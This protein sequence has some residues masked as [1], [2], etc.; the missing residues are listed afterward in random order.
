[1]NLCGLRNSASAILF[2][3]LVFSAPTS[4][5]AADA[6]LLDILLE[7]EQILL[8]RAAVSGE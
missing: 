1:M 4:A 3:G 7:N 6:A 8:L 5:Y 2:A